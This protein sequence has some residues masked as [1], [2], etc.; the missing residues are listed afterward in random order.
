M[1]SKSEYVIRWLKPAVYALPSCSLILG[2]FYYWFALADR[3]LVFLY[4]HDMGPLVPDTSAFSFVTSSRYWM[5]ALVANG[6]VFG[7]YSLF[8]FARNRWNSDFRPPPLTRILLCCTPVLVAGTLLITMQLNQPVLPFKHALRVVLV[9]LLGLALALFGAQLARKKLMALVVLGIDGLALSMLNLTSTWLE[10]ISTLPAWR[11]EIV[12]KLY[13]FCGLLFLISTLIILWRKI[14][15]KWSELFLFSLAISYLFGTA[16]HYV[17]GTDGHFYISN[18]DNFFTRSILL[19]L[20]IWVVTA[21]I[22]FGV[23]RIREVFL[24]KKIDSIN[25]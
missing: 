6:F 8:V 7:L 10:R 2:L 25:E 23:V 16:F 4:N 20:F 13:L 19:Q 24:N 12:F 1:S 17:L 15:I 5:S 11:L 21:L 22:A 9:V 3:D 18:S 14:R